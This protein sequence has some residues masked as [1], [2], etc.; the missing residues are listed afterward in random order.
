[1]RRIQSALAAVRPPVDKP[2]DVDEVI[3]T[4]EALKAATNLRDIGI[5]SL[6]WWRV[7]ATCSRHGILVRY[8]ETVGGPPAFATL[9]CLPCSKE[10]LK[11]SCPVEELEI[12]VGK[13]LPIV[14]E[15][16]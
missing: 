9:A 10:G 6:C 2:I 16:I 15:N 7:K 8:E 3:A 14:G 4:H 12:V 13:Q 11:R 5:G 1:M